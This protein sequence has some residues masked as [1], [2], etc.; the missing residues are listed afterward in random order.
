M[1]GR[2]LTGLLVGSLFLS[3][4]LRAMTGAALAR[5]E[6]PAV[7]LAKTPPPPEAC[8]TPA[9]YAPLLQALQQR[10]GAAEEKETALATWASDLDAAAQDIEQR[11]AELVAA[12]QALRATVA[13]AA[14]ASETDLLQLTGVYENMKPKDA[15]ELFAMMAPDFAA[16]FLA[17]MTPEAAA[18]ILSGL[19][20]DHAYAISVIV[21]GRNA[22]IPLK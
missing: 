9:Q 20:A 1:I 15:A 11:L 13:L 5:E 14:Q 3:A 7:E 2:G 4:G 8:I 18:G 12:E 19:E 6:A 22:E 21:A 10:E 16:G 17:R